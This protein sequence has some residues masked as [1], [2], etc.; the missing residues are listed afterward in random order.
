MFISQSKKSKIFYVIYNN[1]ITN[2]RNKIT[3]KTTSKKEANKFLCE[4]E[5]K[6]NS[7]SLIKSISIQDFIKYFKSHKTELT[8]K[9]IDYYTKEFIAFQDF[10]KIAIK[11]ITQIYLNNYKDYLNN[12]N[13]KNSTVKTKLAR[14]LYV[15]NFAKESNFIDSNIKYKLPKISV[16]QIQKDFL[17]TI[18]FQELLSYCKNNELKDI[19]QIAFETGLRLNESINLQWHCIDFNNK[20]LTLNNKT[21]TTKNRKIRIIPLNNTALEI[22]QSRFNNKQSEY[23]FTY[24]S[25]KWCVS[26]LQYKFKRLCKLIF[27][28]YKNI[29][30]HSLRHSFAS[31]L[32]LNKTSLNTIKELLGHS[33]IATTQRYLHTNLDSLKEAIN[34]LAMNCNS[35]SNPVHQFVQ[36]P[37]IGN[38]LNNNS[39]FQYNSL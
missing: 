15:L 35:N 20:L 24:N 30:F 39:N 36:T 4:F 16:V 10:T 3:T 21:Y 8:K 13:L 28:K 11:D 32:E 22:L 2:K 23:V 12:K 37:L 27:G 6:Y 29:S 31:N 17:T 25:N 1:N 7:N 14:V 19:I 33:N 26:T 34:N 18:E 38:V 5:K 9:V